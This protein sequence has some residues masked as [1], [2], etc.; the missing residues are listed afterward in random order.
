MLFTDRLRP[1]QQFY[2]VFKISVGALC[3]ISSFSNSAAVFARP[4]IASTGFASYYSRRFHGKCCTANGEKVNVYTLTAAHRTLPFGSRVR[5]TN[6]GNAKSVI[7]RINDRGPFGGKR[8]IDLSYSAFQKISKIK[9][10]VI[11]VRI[12]VL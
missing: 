7:V 9:K 3:L 10:G 12:E 2:S 6:L 11:K 1:T 5:V 8:I 4:K